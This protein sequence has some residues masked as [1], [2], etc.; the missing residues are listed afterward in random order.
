[1]AK[2]ISEFESFEAKKT[3]EKHLRITR[4]MIDSEAWRE[5][6]AHEIAVYLML[7]HMF[8]KKTEHGFV[9]AENSRRLIITFAEAKECLKVSGSRFKKAIDKLEAVGLIDVVQRS[10]NMKHA[11]IYGLSDRWQ[12][13]ETDKPGKKWPLRRTKELPEEETPAGYIRLDY[14]K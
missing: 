13:Y 2:K 9:I 4:S 8:F 7:K 1:M 3:T 11:N 14:R 5:L 12:E 10:R 6:G